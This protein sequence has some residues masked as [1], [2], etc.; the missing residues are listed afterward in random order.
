MRVAHRPLAQLPEPARAAITERT[1]KGC[2]VADMECGD[3][4]GVA[5]LLTPPLGGERVF[6]KGLPQDHERAGE[7]ERE[8]AVNPH[9]PPYAPR[10]LWQARAGGW[11]LLAFEG[12]TASPWAD[13]HPG[14]TH[15][16]PTAALLSD[17]ATRPAPDIPLMTAWDRWGPYCDP[18]DQDLLTGDRLLHTDPTATNVMIAPGRAWLI[19]W[20]WAARGPAW[21]DAAIW[22]LR[23]VLD[24]HHTPEQAHAR[25]L[26]IPAYATAPRHGLSVLAEAE[27]RSWEDW[28]A[29]GTT[30]L[31]RTVTAARAFAD[32]CAGIAVGEAGERRGDAAAR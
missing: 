7:L 11:H 13:F 28:Q 27:A 31:E 5:A 2:M 22:A 21:A 25:A 1:G 18:D 30:G 17:L 16:A 20:A 24:G 26:H 32:Y 3:S 8:A 9:L 15:L 10:L 12:L 4:S 6:I 29:Y 14:S 19:D 23:L